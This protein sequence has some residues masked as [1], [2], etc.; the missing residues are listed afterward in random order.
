MSVRR[1]HSILVSS[2]VLAGCMRAAAPSPSN[3]E[4]DPSITFPPFFAQPAVSLG[5]E[6]TVY[7]LDG[8]TLRALTV[9]A[10][11]LR[12]PHDTTVSCGSRW[13]SQQYRVVRQGDVIFI[14]IDEDPK[15]CG[16]A[17]PALDS[18]AS[19]AIHRDG[20]ILRRLLDGQPDVTKPGDAGVSATP[21]EPG[22][23]SPEALG[24]GPSPFLPR[25][26]QD[27]GSPAPAPRP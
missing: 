9:A 8:D 24:D 23:A 4:E 26:W 12:P 6:G 25:S 17:H 27:A 13:E 21:G 16:R 3:H 7:E 2:L 10:R 11:D 14:R 1:T 18:G 20:R 5:T 15:A 19:Y 22:T